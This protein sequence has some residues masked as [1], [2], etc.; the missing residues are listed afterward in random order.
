MKCFIQVDLVENDEKVKVP[1]LSF[2]HLSSTEANSRTMLCYTS[3]SRVSLSII[4]IE[5]PFGS[6]DTKGSSN[7]FGLF[8]SI[9]QFEKTF[10][11]LE[12]Q[13]PD[14]PDPPRSQ[15]PSEHPGKI[16]RTSREH[17]ENTQR[18]SGENPTSN[19][20]DHLNTS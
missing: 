9:L 1:E 5:I 16:L 10:R 19:I 18:R 3:F 14:P 7:S 20:C 12:A 6:W 4:P 17:Q 11:L 13:G 15:D 2:K 8:K